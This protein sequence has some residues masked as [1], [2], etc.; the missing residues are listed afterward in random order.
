M[1][2]SPAWD[3]PL[4]NVPSVDWSYKRRDLSHVEPDQR[5]KKDEYDRYLFLV[6]FYKKCNFDSDYIHQNCPYKVLDIGIISIL[7]RAS[8]DLIALCAAIPNSEETEEL[9][10]CIKRTEEAIDRLWHKEKG[11]F[12]SYDVLTNTR[13]E[14]ITS[15]TVLPLFAGLPNAEQ[16]AAMG[17]LLRGWID[18]TKYALSSTHPESKFFEAKRYW[19]GPIWLHINWM[20]AEGLIAYDM[21]KLAEDLKESS[22][23]CLHDA[24]YWEYFDAERGTG[25]G[26][27]DFSWT[28]AIGM[29][30]LDK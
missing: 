28:A 21:L 12:V 4:A 15:A 29:H 24:G 23:R 22:L 6:D 7:H 30:W 9:V 5:P 27:E 18:K 3:A 26:G 19:R 14:E 20:I 16:A 2:N 25:C 17:D 13:L 10:L 1:D 11:C 8:T